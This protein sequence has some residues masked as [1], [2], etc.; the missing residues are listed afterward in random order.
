MLNVFNAVSISI[1]AGC[2]VLV[3]CVIEASISMWPG[4]AR[5]AEMETRDRAYGPAGKST[6]EVIWTVSG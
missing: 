5:A 6:G 2:V 1:R 3:S 4:S